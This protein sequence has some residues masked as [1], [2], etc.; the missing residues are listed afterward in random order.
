MNRMPYG[1]I[2]VPVLML[3]FT[4]ALRADVITVDDDGPADFER[5]QEAIEFAST[6]DEVL[7]RAGYYVENIDFL[8]KGIEVRS[9]DGPLQT[10][11][12]SLPDSGMPTVTFASKESPAALLDGFRQR[13]PDHGLGV[14][15]DFR[16]Q[17]PTALARPRL[18][19]G[20]A[21][22]E[23]DDQGPPLRACRDGLWDLG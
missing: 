18:R 9:K 11:I 13:L 15:R 17:R 14:A 21:S 7:V 22:V 10:T 12:K 6:G 20:V 1:S 3:G 4:V 2:L 5:I 23:P 8:G 19:P 16:D